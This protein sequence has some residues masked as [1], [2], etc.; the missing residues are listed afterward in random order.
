MRFKIARPQDCI[1]ISCGLERKERKNAPE[2]PM[3]LPTEKR[4]MPRYQINRDRDREAALAA[5]ASFEAGFRRSRRGNLWRD[6]ENVTLTIYRRK[7]AFGFGWC[8]ADGEQ[9]RFSSGR[10]ETEED[11]LSALGS[12]LLDLGE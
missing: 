8:I 1:K 2:V 4:P 3:A 5:R 11:A 6:W 12:E 10:Y 7:D 9:P